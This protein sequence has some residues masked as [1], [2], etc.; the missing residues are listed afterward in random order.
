MV[1]LTSFATVGLCKSRA[2]AVTSSPTRSLFG[3]GPGHLSWMTDFGVVCQMLLPGVARCDCCLMRAVHH[4]K[5]VLCCAYMPAA[6][7]VCDNSCLMGPFRLQ[8]WNCGKGLVDGFHAGVCCSG[9]GSITTFLKQTNRAPP[10]RS[11]RARTAGNAYHQPATRLFSSP[12]FFVPFQAI[13]ATS[14][15]LRNFHLDLHGACAS[16]KHSSH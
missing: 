7:R 8:L 9:H 10:Q 4:S 16:A 14:L 11:C 12:S 15:H 6:C 13:H 3:P 2:T 1:N 5:E